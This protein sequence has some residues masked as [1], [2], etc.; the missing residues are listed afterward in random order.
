MLPKPTQGKR[1]QGGARRRKAH[2]AM[3]RGDASRAAWIAHRAL[4]SCKGGGAGGAAGV[5]ASAVGHRRMRKDACPEAPPSPHHR[6]QPYVRPSGGPQS[7]DGT[8]AELQQPSPPCRCWSSVVDGAPTG[9]SGKQ[10]GGERGRG[11]WERGGGGERG[12]EKGGA[13]SNAPGCRQQRENTREA[14]SR[15]QRPLPQPKIHEGSM[16]SP[17]HDSSKKRQMFE[18]STPCEESMGT[19]ASG[20]KRQHF[21]ARET[22]A[23]LSSKGDARVGWGRGH[24]RNRTAGHLWCFPSQGTCGGVSRRRGR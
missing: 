21:R 8:L 4:P 5:L 18:L 19:S 6:H 2:R 24:V 3:E 17:S 12:G 13:D 23:A 16:P 1:A 9:G 10:G 11:G 7:F 22:A 20:S 15:S 14:A